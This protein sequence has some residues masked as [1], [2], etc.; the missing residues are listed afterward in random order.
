MLIKTNLLISAEQN[1]EIDRSM[2]SRLR[3]SMKYLNCSTPGLEKKVEER[4]GELNK[5]NMELA[6]AL[7]D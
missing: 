3:Q 2:R 6:E 7:H 1:E 4:T 5:S